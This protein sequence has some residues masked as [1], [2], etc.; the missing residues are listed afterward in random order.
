VFLQTF[1]QSFN[2]NPQRQTTNL[3][4]YGRIIQQHLHK[5]QSQSKTAKAKHAP[6]VLEIPG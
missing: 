4:N 3:K 5:G 6:K 1:P 2:T